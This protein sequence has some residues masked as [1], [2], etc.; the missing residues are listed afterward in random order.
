MDEISL[1]DVKEFFKF[2]IKKIWIV[3]IL[4]IIIFA[5]GLFYSDFIKVPMYRS[6]TSLILATNENGADAGSTI[7]QTDISINQNLVNTYAEIIKSRKV[8]NSTKKDLKLKD[9]YSDLVNSISVDSKDGTEII[10]VSV[11]NKDPKLA[12]EIADSVAENF[13]QEVIKIYNM[14]NVSILDSAEISKVPYNHNTTKEAVIYLFSG[15]LLGIF[16]LFLW[17]YFDKTIKNSEEVETKIALPI[18]GKIRDC[19]KIINKNKIGDKLLIKEMP[20]TN[21][22]EDIKTIRTNLDFSNMDHNVKRLLITSSI[23]GEGKS[24]VSANLAA[25]F[26]QNNK[27]VILVDCDLRKG[28]VHK[29]FGIKN[30]GLSNLIAK[31]DLSSLSD[32]ICKTDVNNLDVLTR[33]TVPPNPSELLNSRTFGELLKILDGQYDYIILDGTPVT[34]LPDALITSSYADKTLIVCSIGYTPIDLLMNT[35]KS[36]EN[37]GA[38]IAGVIVNK[39]EENHG[40]YY[41]STYKYE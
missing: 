25:S 38:S 8:L 11:V 19:T 17:F 9:S 23:T 14:K 27:K 41:Y 16:I 36:L 24:F 22:A 39:V 34:N 26:A 5:G 29:R 20:K 6:T 10:S 15:I 7:T 40:G 2:F 28:V 12:K 35:K 32:Y 37:V 3:I 21:F 33:G 1:N 30:K 31:N 13:R 18:M 4:T